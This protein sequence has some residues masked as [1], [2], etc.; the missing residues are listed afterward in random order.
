MPVVYKNPLYDLSKKPKY[1][2]KENVIKEIERLTSAIEA[3]ALSE[4]MDNGKSK[5]ASRKKK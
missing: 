2:N 3:A 5:G 1:Q 4:E